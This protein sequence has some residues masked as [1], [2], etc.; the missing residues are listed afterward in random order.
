MG[1]LNGVEKMPRRVRI[2]ATQIEDMAVD[3]LDV[4]IG[5]VNTLQ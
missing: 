5:H 1:R 2:V 4:S 3:A